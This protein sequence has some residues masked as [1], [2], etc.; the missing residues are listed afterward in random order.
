MSEKLTPHIRKKQKI[1]TQKPMSRTK[2][3]QR[4]RC[5]A[6]CKGRMGIET[7]SERGSDK[8][9]ITRSAWCAPLCSVIVSS[10]PRC[11]LI[12]SYLCW[13]EPSKYWITLLRLHAQD[14]L[15]RAPFAL[16]APKTNRTDARRQVIRRSS[17]HTIQY[18][19]VFT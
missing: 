7:E 1:S 15:G 13:K 12:V 3:E 11:C 6:R 4:P 10:P 5:S 8:R 2:I 18:P 17:F 14:V 16:D 9:R 19:G